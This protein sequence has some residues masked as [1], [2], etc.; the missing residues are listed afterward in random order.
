M[1]SNEGYLREAASG[2]LRII[3]GTTP[4]DYEQLI[5]NHA[6]QVTF[7]RILKEVQILLSYLAVEDDPYEKSMWIKKMV[8]LPFDTMEL[9]A[10]EWLE[11]VVRKLLLAGT[12]VDQRRN[13]K[14]KE[15][16]LRNLIIFEAKK[17]LAERIRDLS[18]CKNLFEVGIVAGKLNV[19]TSLRYLKIQERQYQNGRTILSKTYEIKLTE[20]FHFGGVAKLAVLSLVFIE[21]I[22]SED[23]NQGEI[24]SFTF[25]I[26][27]EIRL[28]SDTLH[29]DL[30]RMVLSLPVQA[31]SNDAEFCASN[32]KNIKTQELLLQ[33]T[34]DALSIIGVPAHIKGYEYLRD[35]ILMAYENPYITMTK[36]LYPRLA[37]TYSS[38]SSKVERAI[39]HAI[40]I[41]WDKSKKHATSIA[42]V[43][44]D[45]PPSNAEFI[46][47]IVDR[48]KM[49]N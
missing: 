14:E 33:K 21:P 4:Q 20:V 30:T 17:F 26:D 18:V 13:D 27:N 5:I 43:K 45:K 32:T 42:M 3:F 10:I 9:S 39:R 36:D 38:T 8:P 31:Y 2:V 1:K 19:E 40:K 48:L 6:N 23:Y 22:H 47:F 16:E 25:D 44:A 49:K 37:E 28:E 24:A 7:E 35:A 15:E 46:Y 34:S 41:A 12:E 29:T 11:L